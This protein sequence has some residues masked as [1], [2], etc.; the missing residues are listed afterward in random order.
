MASPTLIDRV[1]HQL[2]LRAVDPTP[3]RVAAVLREDGVVLG[4]DAVLA[5][6]QTLRDDIAGAGPLERW[7]RASGV[8]DVLVNGP[9]E[10]WVDAGAGLQRVDAGF[11]TDEAVRR[12]A[13]RLA[14]S[15]GRR[16]DDAS[17]FIDAR[18]PDGSRLHAILPPIA[19]E[20]TCI[21]L[22]IPRRQA[23]TLD[24]LVRLGTMDDTIAAWLRSL[25]RAR[26]SFLIS[27]GTGS[28]KTTILS[29]LLGECAPSERLL[30]VED[31]TELRPDHPHVVRLES[32][33]ANA[34]GAGGVNLRDLVRQALRMR[35]DR[36][37]VGEVRGAETLDLLSALNTGHEGG[38]GTIHAN[39]AMDVPARVEALGMTAGL[40]REAVRAL[41]V[42]GLDAV[43]HLAKDS[44]QRRVQS[45]AMFVE[46]EM[47]EALVWNGSGYQPGP[48]YARLR[49]RLSAWCP[50]QGE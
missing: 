27:G 37:I 9:G 39:S 1:R 4:D 14:A 33:P 15:A 6:V 21:S 10:V 19:R 45:L 29:T 26:M 2:V 11:P 31:S 32:R 47:C 13:Q 23:F 34:E 28:G 17:P 44:G 8:T 7:M 46:D 3:A 42:C 48:A 22:R 41:L 43:I 16:L 40:P 38:C 36:V 18:L 25:I 30:I 12:L 35:P 20:G 5:L 24:E 49:D 50:P